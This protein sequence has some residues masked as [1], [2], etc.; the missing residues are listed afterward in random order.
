MFS[1]HSAFLAT[2]AILDALVA[3]LP[4]LPWRG[5][6]EE[7]V[8]F[9]RR[10]VLVQGELRYKVRVVWMQMVYALNS[11]SRAQVFANS[12]TGGSMSKG[13]TVMEILRILQP[14]WLPGICF[15]PSR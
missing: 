12:L 10:P 14:S 15:F 11:G 4:A 13:V 9:T 8:V 2:L 1:I 7:V 3:Q 6:V 5:V